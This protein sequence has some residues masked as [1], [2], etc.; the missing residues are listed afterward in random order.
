MAG[1][2]K[3]EENTEG[4]EQERTQDGGAPHTANLISVGIALGFD[5]VTLGAGLLLED[6][7]LIPPVASVGWSGR[8]VG[9]WRIG[10]HGVSSLPDRAGW[11]GR[12]RRRERA[13][14]ERPA[15][16]DRDR[17]VQRDCRRGDGRSPSG[18]RR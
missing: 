13:A 14:E 16:R 8:S 7:A 2:H 1:L 10:S 12:W 4:D 9:W 11:R 15:A 17:R 18:R 3:Q 6:L 5:H